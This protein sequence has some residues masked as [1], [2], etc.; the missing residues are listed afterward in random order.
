MCTT[1]S[2]LRNGETLLGRT[3]DLD[4]IIDMNLSISQKILTTKKMSLE[5]NY[6]LN[7]R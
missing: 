5:I 4:L 1:F 7:I 2:I 6:I 3:M